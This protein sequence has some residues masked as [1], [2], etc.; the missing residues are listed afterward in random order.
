MLTVFVFLCFRWVWCDT[1]YG[2]WNFQVKY[3][4]VSKLLT[5]HVTLVVIAG[6]SIL[7]PYHLIKVL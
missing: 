7:V 5:G 2:D 4:S 1:T 3:A 6:T